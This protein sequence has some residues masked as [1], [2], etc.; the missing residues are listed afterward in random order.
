MKNLSLIIFILLC[1]TG[2]RQTEKTEAV[3]AEIEASQMEDARL[4]G[5]NA[6]KR[7]INREWKDSTERMNDMAGVDSIAGTYSDPQSAATFKTTFRSTLKAVRPD[8]EKK[9]REAEEEQ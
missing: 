1:L 5:R 2:C 4:N 3:T 8:L 9:L 6:A 7:L